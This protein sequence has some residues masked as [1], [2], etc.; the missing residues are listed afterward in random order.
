MSKTTLTL[1]VVS[2]ALLL[3]PSVSAQS[4][5]YLGP[6]DGEADGSEGVLGFND[7][8]S[9]TFDGAQMCESIDVLRSGS[10]VAPGTP[11]SLP[12]DQTYV[13]CTYRR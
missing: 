11:P 1:A 13:A 5:Q 12:V 8:C 6:S 3:T 2:L 4:L 9:A 7:L 10:P